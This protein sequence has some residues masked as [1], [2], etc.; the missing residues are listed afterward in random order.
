MKF[1][2][3]LL[4]LALLAATARADATEPDITFN[5]DVEDACLTPRVIADAL[6]QALFVE[7][8]ANAT[9][10]LL[11]PD[12][13]QHN[14][15]VPTGAAP[16]LGFIPALE[17][18]GLGIETHR[19]IE[20]GNL[21]AYHSTY[22]NASLFGGDTLVGFDV[23]RVEDGLVQEH[24]DN[25]QEL[26]GP[27]PDGNT[28]TDGATMVKYLGETEYN[29]WLVTSFIEEVFMGGNFSALPY[30]I[31]SEMYIQHNPDAANGID[32]FIEAFS[33]ALGNIT[34][35]SIE[36]VVAQGNFVLVGGEGTGGGFPL[37]FYDLFRVQD[38]FLVE[39]WDVI[40]AIPAPEDFAHDNGKW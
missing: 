25:L 29:Q 37:A 10:A 3:A 32:G 33:G 39:H 9:A 31:S 40:Q 28:M 23:F 27:N 21:V 30:Y 17:A 4:H 5:G 34:Y 12:Y 16:V 11:A 8:D 6:V 2:V 24:W 36:F 15:G 14:P 22:T 20:M 1:L 26:A 35:D 7:F 18:S 19:T 38:E 13:I